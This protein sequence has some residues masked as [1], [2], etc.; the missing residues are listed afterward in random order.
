MNKSEVIKMVTEIVCE[1]DYDIYKQAYNHST[2]E[3]PE[4]VDDNIADLIEIVAKHIEIDY[5][6]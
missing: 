3:G 4:S 2:A 1:V 5:E 6:H